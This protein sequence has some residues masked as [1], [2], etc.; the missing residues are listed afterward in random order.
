MLMAGL[1]GI[2]R[3][4]EPPKP[5]DKNLYAL[6]AREARRIRH[7]PKTLDEA[8][9]ALE[10]DHAFLLKGGVFTE[11]LLEEW[12]RLKREEAAQVRLRPSPME[13]H[14]YYDL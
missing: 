14:L 10:R 4:L 3:G 6:P 7:L 12:I 13:Y 5:V 11:D 8:L 9:D 1:D 2:E